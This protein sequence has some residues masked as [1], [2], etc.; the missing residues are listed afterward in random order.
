MKKTMVYLLAML[1]FTAGCS[2]TQSAMKTEAPPLVVGM[3]LDNPPMTFRNGEGLP[4]GAE[5][6][7][8]NALGAQLHRPVRIEVLPWGQLV[9]ALQTH[10]VDI[11]M[12]GVSVTEAREAKVLFSEP[13]TTISQMI[14][15]KEGAALPL[16]SYEGEGMRIAF[17]AGTTAEHFVKARFA[18]ATM[19]PT[20]TTRNGM[21]ALLGGKSDYYVT[22]APAVWFYSA[23]NGLPGIVGRYVPY[24][25]EN[26]A[27]AMAADNVVLKQEVDAVLE[28]WIKDGFISKV[29]NRWI[30]VRIVTPNYNEPVTFE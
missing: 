16:D 3:D 13:Y 15:M 6:E 8:A 30:P 27:W 22:D 14:L 25:R 4:S 28:R 24:T 9:Q 29:L 18:A 5:V 2:T 17:Q 10:A 26:L 23:S 20:D 1:L 21:V 19:I 7:F 11:V 12:S